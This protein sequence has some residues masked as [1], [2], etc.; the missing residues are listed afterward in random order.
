[1]REDIQ[2]QLTEET[3]PLSEEALEKE[4][5]LQGLGETDGVSL[6]RYC[7]LSNSP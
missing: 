3:S 2:I 7:K 1:M 6:L 5:K 4:K